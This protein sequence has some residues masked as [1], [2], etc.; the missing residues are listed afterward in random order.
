MARTGTRFGSIGRV[1]MEGGKEL[2]LDN[3]NFSGQAGA[4]QQIESTPD[5]PNRAAL[6]A[7]GPPR[8]AAVGSRAPPH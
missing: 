1:E 5:A 8:K 2:K 4:T 6:Q 7:P 3:P